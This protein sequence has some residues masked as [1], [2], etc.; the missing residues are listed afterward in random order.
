MGHAVMW[1]VH[2]M[3]IERSHG[4]QFNHGGLLWQGSLFGRQN[5][6]FAGIRDQISIMFGALAIVLSLGCEPSAP[7]VKPSDPDT[8]AIQIESPSSTAG[9]PAIEP[10]LEQVV[11]VQIRRST[12]TEPLE[13][14]SAWSSGTTVFEALMGL[15]P[16]VAVESTGQ[17]ESL[18]VKSIAGQAN[19]G[20]A[21]DNW[22]YRVNGKL[23]DCS[24]AVYELEAGDTVVWSFGK[25]E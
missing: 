22:I 25:Y 2:T 18:F 14:T 11:N 7:V 4:S 16:A 10:G 6:N 21:G 24:C 9:K 13:G 12:G 15:S 19:L 17:G 5:K 8:P 3:R 20:S 1:K 23:G